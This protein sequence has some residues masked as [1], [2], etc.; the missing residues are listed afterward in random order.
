MAKHKLLGRIEGNLDVRDWIIISMLE[1]DARVSFAEIGRRANLSPPA[2]A[3]RLRRLED[4]GVITGYHAKVNT[5]RLGLG[6]LV[7]IE[8]QVKRGA[9]SDF[10]KAVTKLSWILECHHITGRASFL[11][12]AAVPDVAGLELLVGHLSQFGDTNTSV[13]LSTLVARRELANAGGG[14]GE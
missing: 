6:M 8:M 12:K 11:L 9:Y 7:Y 14:T 2:A 4:A 10:E 3:E 13:I 1:S 5:E